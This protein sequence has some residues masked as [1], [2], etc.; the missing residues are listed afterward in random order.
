MGAVT[1]ATKKGIQSYT[2]TAF[3]FNVLLDS[4]LQLAAFQNT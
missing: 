1:G 4:V 2:A 3:Q